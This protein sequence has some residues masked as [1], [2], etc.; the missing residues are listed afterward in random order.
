MATKPDDLGDKTGSAPAAEPSLEIPEEKA[1]AP[2]SNCEDWAGRACVAGTEEECALL[3]EIWKLAE[4][5]AVCLFNARHYKAPQ[6]VGKNISN[7]LSA[8]KAL[9][10]CVAELDLARRGHQQVVTVQYGDVSPGQQIITKDD[11]FAKSDQMIDSLIL[12]A[13]EILER[14]KVHCRVEADILHNTP[15]GELV[16]YINGRKFGT[17]RRMWEEE[18]TAI[19]NKVSQ[20]SSKMRLLV[21]KRREKG[22]QRVIVNYVGAVPVKKKSLVFPPANTQDEAWVSPFAIAKIVKKAGSESCN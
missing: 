12:E 3:Q 8:L 4:Q 18:F 15:P 13:L 11:P 19:A 14:W 6:A 21:V 10:A 16:R 5:S 7:G 17:D 1:G 22:H 20:Q 9:F 2:L